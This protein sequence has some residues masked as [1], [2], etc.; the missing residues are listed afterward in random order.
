M[1]MENYIKWHHKETIN[2]TQKMGIVTGQMIHFLQQ[3]NA[4][5]QSGVESNSVD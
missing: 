3:V 4:L 5:K 1:R 2:Q